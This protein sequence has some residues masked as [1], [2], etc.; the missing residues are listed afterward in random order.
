MNSE[1]GAG[2]PHV[3]AVLVGGPDWLGPELR[4]VDIEASV[5]QIKML[6]GNRYEHFHRVPEAGS[7]EQDAR[8]FE[9]SHCTYVAE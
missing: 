3:K 8:V 4:V 7:Q 5:S 1:S 9:W 6:S 2:P